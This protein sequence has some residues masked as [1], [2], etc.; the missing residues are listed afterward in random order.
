MVIRSKLHCVP[1]TF[2]DL[3]HIQCQ[4]ALAN[5]TRK[6]SPPLICTLHL[7]FTAKPSACLKR[8]KKKITIIHIKKKIEDKPIVYSP[9]FTVWAVSKTSCSSLGRD[10]PPPARPKSETPRLDICVGQRPATSSGGKMPCA[11]LGALKLLQGT[12]HSRCSSRHRYTEE[13]L[14][15]RR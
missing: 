7:R 10:T 5:K 14:R 8:K 3:I 11:G 6:L 12:R 13:V 9:V 2:D 4:N 1:G 15:P